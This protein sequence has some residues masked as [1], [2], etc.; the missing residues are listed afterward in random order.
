[1]NGTPQPLL[2][3]NQDPNSY[4]SDVYREVWSPVVV[5]ISVR[6]A[7]PANAFDGNRRFEGAIAF[8]VQK[9]RTRTG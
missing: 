3:V 4:A 5:E 7:V 2:R 1:L 9:C 6:D 8:A